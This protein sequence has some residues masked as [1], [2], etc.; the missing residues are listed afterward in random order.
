[1]VLACQQEQQRLAEAK[2]QEQEQKKLLEEQKAKDLAQAQHPGND[3]VFL[4]SGQTA[5]RA[6]K[7]HRDPR[8]D[9][10]STGSSTLCFSYSLSIAKGPCERSPRLSES[11]WPEHV[12][13]DAGD[14]REGERRVR[15]G[16]R[17]LGSGW[18]SRQEPR[19]CGFG[20]EPGTATG[21]QPSR[22]CGR[23]VLQS[24]HADPVNRK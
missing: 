5:P 10:A 21:W 23:A 20:S 1:M 16:S 8:T 15:G 19:S 18:S 9:A 6:G 11:R 7:G 4:L 2:R 24:L 13:V 14:R 17:S 22:C 3:E 12:R